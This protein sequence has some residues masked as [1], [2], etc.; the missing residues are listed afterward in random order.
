MGGAETEILVAAADPHCRIHK[1]VQGRGV[2]D[3][4]QGE[5]FDNKRWHTVDT[6]FL[7]L[8]LSG[9]HCAGKGPTAEKMQRQ[10]MI[11]PLLRCDVRQHTRIAD[12]VAIL[13]KG[14]ENGENEC[15]AVATGRGPFDKAMRIHCIRN[16]LN[17]IEVDGT[18]KFLRLHFDQLQQSIRSFPAA[19]PGFKVGVKRHSFV[20]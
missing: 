8:N 10:I 1:S 4:C 5:S 20:L 13:E 12:I 19:M 9:S 16:M 3:A 11:E 18:L 14:F 17:A 7:R 2:M 15:S 6:R